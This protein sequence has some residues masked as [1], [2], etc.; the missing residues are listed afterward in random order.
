MS[1]RRKGSGHDEGTKE[2]LVDLVTSTEGHWPDNQPAS[3]HLEVG[4]ETKNQLP[5][6]HPSQCFF[7]AGKTP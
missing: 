6:T 2:L 5:R 1:N 3:G 4:K 7:P